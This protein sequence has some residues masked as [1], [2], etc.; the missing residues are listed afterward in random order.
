MIRKGSI[1]RRTN[2][3]GN[4]IGDY[5]QVVSIDKNLI[6]CKYVSCDV[7]AYVNKKRYIELKKR[8]VKVSSEDYLKLKLANIGIYKHITTA[9]FMRLEDDLPDIVAFY[10]AKK[11]ML[12][13]RV[14]MVYPVLYKCKNH[15]MIELISLIN[16]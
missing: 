16:K 5:L 3:F 10:T 9:Q 14:G 8:T 11:P 1:I 15:T 4:P 12:Y 13:Y 7:I 6:K 2:I